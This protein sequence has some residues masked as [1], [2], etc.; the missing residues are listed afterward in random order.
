MYENSGGEVTAISGPNNQVIIRTDIDGMLGVTCNCRYFWSYTLFCSHTFAVF[1][2]LQVR[3]LNRFRPFYRWTRKYH[4][5]KIGDDE[6]ASNI[7]RKLCDKGM[8]D[9]ETPASNSNSQ[10]VNALNRNFGMAN[11]EENNISLV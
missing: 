11:P 10:A 6:L 1:H 9:D 7:A 3:N 4:N 2:V 5:V 8:C